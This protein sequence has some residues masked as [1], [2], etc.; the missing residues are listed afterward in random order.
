MSTNVVS[1]LRRILNM[2]SEE[3]SSIYTKYHLFK[4]NIFHG[5]CQQKYYFHFV[6]HKPRQ[7]LSNNLYFDYWM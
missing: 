6:L 1:L 4:K 5:S 7:T 3:G 2:V